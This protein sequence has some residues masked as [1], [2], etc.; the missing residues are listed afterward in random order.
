MYKPLA[1]AINGY[2]FFIGRAA[3]SYGYVKGGANGRVFGALVTDC[4]IV[5]MFVLSLVTIGN[6]GNI[7]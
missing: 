6:W 3:F 7:N 5:S 4:S 1:A 2:V